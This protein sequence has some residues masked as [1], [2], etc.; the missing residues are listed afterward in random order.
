MLRDLCFEA[1]RNTRTHWLR[2][3]LTSSGIIW[4][5]ALFIVMIAIGEANRDH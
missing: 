5:I 1:W 2:V 4:G 3:L